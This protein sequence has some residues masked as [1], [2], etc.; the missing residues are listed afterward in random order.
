MIPTT[1]PEPPIPTITNPH[2]TRDVQQICGAAARL[3]QF[4]ERLEAAYAPL[5]AYVYVRPLQ[6]EIVFTRPALPR[7]A[8]LFG[9]EGWRREAA[10]GA[11]FD[12]LKRVEE[13]VTL[14]ISECE[15]VASAQAEVPVAMVGA[16]AGGAG[17]RVAAEISA[18]VGA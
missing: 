13:G 1:P 15:E 6:A 18:E 5:P 2:L 9:R 12:W 14:R 11:Y 16:A 17:A 3:Q 7:L 8:Q 4:G 10:G